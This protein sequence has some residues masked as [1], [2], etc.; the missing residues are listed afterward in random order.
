MPPLPYLLTYAVSGGHA[1][2]LT[3]S[4]LIVVF[5]SV[6]VLT[7]FVGL[8][9]HLPRPIPLV[10]ALLSVPIYFG[11]PKTI[12]YDACTQVLVA[13][14][15]FAT[16]RDF[17]LLKR[18]C[19]PSRASV[20]GVGGSRSTGP[21]PPC[22]Q[23]SL[24]GRGWVGCLDHVGCRGDG[25]VICPGFRHCRLRPCDASLLLR[26]CSVFMEIHIYKD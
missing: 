7:L 19:Y 24:Q 6:L 2:W 11:L 20:R 8:A 16:N 26:V 22:I 3:E 1:T 4:T 5:Q 25:P 21:R 17:L 12:F 15:A 23:S 9:S 13:L 10:A 18:R 14:T